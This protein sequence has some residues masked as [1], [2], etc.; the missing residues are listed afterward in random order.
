M[1]HR[2]VLLDSFFEFCKMLLNQQEKQVAPKSSGVRSASKVF[3]TTYTDVEFLE[4]LEVK[5]S[6]TEVGRCRKDLTRT[7]YMN[8]HNKLSALITRVSV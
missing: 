4:E 6:G 8:Q 7:Y 2:N 3:K 5:R 1:A